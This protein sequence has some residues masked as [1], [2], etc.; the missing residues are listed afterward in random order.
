MGGSGGGFFGGSTDAD[1][2]IRK[3]RDA[4]VKASNT[5]FDSEVSAEIS[6]LHPQINNRDVEAVNTHLDG[7][8]SALEKNIE[9]TIDLLFGGSVARH[10]YV[11]GL[12]DVDSLVLL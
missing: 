12:S 8:K 6:S 10:T 1:D 4:E 11:D 7:I 2:L 9:G 3:G 5:E